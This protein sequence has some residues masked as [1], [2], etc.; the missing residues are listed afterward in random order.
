[1]MV[2]NW[3]FVIAA[4]SAAWIGVV[5]YWVFVHRAVRRARERY[6]LSIAAAARAEGKAR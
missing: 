4:Y 1:M 3:T 5:G 6:E 2:N